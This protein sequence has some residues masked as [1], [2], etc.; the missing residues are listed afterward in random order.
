MNFK[1]IKKVV[2]CSLAS[3]KTLSLKVLAWAGIWEKTMN[4]ILDWTMPEGK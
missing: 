4:N 2:L 3:I 1:I